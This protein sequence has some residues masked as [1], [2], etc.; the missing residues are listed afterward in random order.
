MFAGM[1]M[2][3]APP[4]FLA[5][6]LIVPAWRVF[7]RAGL[8]PLWSLCLFIP[9]FGPLIVVLMLAFTRWPATEG[10]RHED[11]A[12]PPAGGEG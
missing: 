4:L 3:V 12:M 7:D 9:V 6:V 10:P 2:G 1:T 8:N 5:L 11:R